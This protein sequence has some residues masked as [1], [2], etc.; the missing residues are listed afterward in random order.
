MEPATGMGASSKL[1]ST[2]KELPLWLLSSFAVGLLVLLYMPALDGIIP[3]EAR[4]WLVIAAILFAFLAIFRLGSLLFSFLQEWIKTRNRR[5]RRRLDRLYQPLHDLFLSRHVTMSTSVG[6]PYLRYRI[7]RAIE[8]CSS[9]RNRYAGIKSAFRAIVDKQKST[10]AE[11]EYGGDFPLQLIRN[12]ITR[13]TGYADMELLN[14]LRL[15]DRALYEDPKG[16]GL[17]S[18]AEL[19]LFL[20]IEEQFCRLKKKYQ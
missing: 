14:L 17:L 6:A 18:E 1:L 13:K 9:R 19:N 5:E 16:S 15:A 8:L 12:I 10:S 7:E 20:H 3:A 4:S 11:V 2:L